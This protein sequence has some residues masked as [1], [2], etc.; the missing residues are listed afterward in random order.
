MHGRC[1]VLTVASNEN[2]DK[3]DHRCILQWEAL[4]KNRDQEGQ[5]LRTQWEQVWFLPLEGRDGGPPCP[6]SQSYW[7]IRKELRFAW[8][9]LSV[10][11]LVSFHFLQ[12]QL[13]P[14]CGQMSPLHHCDSMSLWLWWLCSSSSNVLLSLVDHKVLELWFSRE[15]RMLY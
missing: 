5:Y 14:S 10:S 1:L 2:T 7:E 11:T 15:G 3:G 9:P 6:L 13:F 12:C 4:E 8:F